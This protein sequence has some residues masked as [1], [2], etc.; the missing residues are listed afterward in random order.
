[1]RIINNFKARMAGAVQSI[2]RYPIVIIWLL[3]ITVLN[4]NQIQN[5]FDLYSR[6]LFTSLTGAMLA[7]VAQH[8]YERQTNKAINRWLLLIIS[9]FLAILYYF[10]LPSNH[11][12]DLIYPIR[13]IVLLFSLFIAFIWMPSLNSK[14]VTFHSNF[15][16]IFKAA[17]MTLLVTVVLSL[18]VLAILGSVDFLL[19]NVDSDLYSH[20]MNIIA[21]LFA[22]IYFLS[23]VPEYEEDE[24]TYR[25][26]AEVPRFLERLLVY[27]VIPLVAIYTF[28]LVAYVLI[29]IG[30]E[31]WTNNLLESLLVSYAIIVILVYLLV[32]N[33]EHKYSQLFQKIFPKIM[34]VVVL[35]QTVA[36]ILRIQDLGMTHGRYY[37]IM[38][39]IFASVAAI[40]FSFFAK[41]KSGW[42]APVLIVL[43]LISVSPVVDAFSVARRSQE[44]LLED[45][46]EKN[47][48]LVNGDIVPKA[49]IP[50]E[51]KVVITRSVE[52]LTVWGD[53]E[54]IS[55]LPD[56][57]D[58]YSDFREVFGFNMTYSDSPEE[59]PTARYVY[60]NWEKSPVVPLEEADY[61]VKTNL[62]MEEIMEYQLND[63]YKLIKEDN[64]NLVLEDVS[65]DEVIRFNMTD[66][67]EKAL[68][69]GS[70]TNKGNEA[71]LETMLETQENDQVKMTVVIQQL[72]EFDNRVGGEFFIFITIK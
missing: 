19:F 29:N 70:E 49:D 55:L 40:I 31:F 4:A 50:A 61:L 48:M 11:D 69:E 2:S 22:P 16:A 12:Y 67:F 17:M 30:G 68:N 36:S 60:Y 54:Q 62:Y 41:E 57:F 9:V 65:G 25:Q 39:G 6:W 47:A 27:V 3:I 59:K 44:N 24:S 53:E 23:L 18:G 46:L 37:V 1:M 20:A 66:L 43:S 35:F 28:V 13:T 56:E 32:C 63:T 33:I 42:I 26:A 64:T 71:T 58:I 14:R 10:T 8:V 51:D 5:D 34:L 45:K 21:C 72:E 52:Y 15:L 38:F 7:L